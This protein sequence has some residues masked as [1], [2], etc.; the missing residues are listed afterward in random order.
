[1]VLRERGFTTR[2]QI[3]PGL[4]RLLNE[5]QP[6]IA[7][8][9]ASRYKDYPLPEDYDMQVILASHWSIHLILSSHWSQAFTPL[10]SVLARYN[11][12]QVM[13]GETLDKDILARL[14]CARL[15]NIGMV[16]SRQSP[17]VIT[18]SK[19]TNTFEA[20]DVDWRDVREDPAVL[21]EEIE[22]LEDIDSSEDSDS[23]VPVWDEASR[24][25]QYS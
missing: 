12:K 9:D 10:Q 1:M 21:V 13:R 7:E 3:W 16:L 14:R 24:L 23:P 6:L 25:G 22:M 8:F 15:V 20:V 18:F 4:A 5:V 19:V 2:P 11:M 17:A